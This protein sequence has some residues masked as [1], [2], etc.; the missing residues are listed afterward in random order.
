MCCNSVKMIC[1]I[2]SYFVISFWRKFVIYT[3]FLLYLFHLLLSSCS[4]YFIY[5]FFRFHFLCFFH[6]LSIYWKRPYWSTTTFAR[7]KNLF[8]APGFVKPFNKMSGL[9]ALHSQSG[10]PGGLDWSA[11][12]CS[13]IIVRC[14][15]TDRPLT[16][17]QICYRCKRKNMD[18][19]GIKLCYTVILLAELITR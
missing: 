17:H 11:S 2:L 12:K 8:E 6:S 4:F 5:V 3:I 15:V 13:F 19:S 18:I 9:F 16:G 7:Q 14:K 1:T 10:T